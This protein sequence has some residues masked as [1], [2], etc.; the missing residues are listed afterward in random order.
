MDRACL[1][2]HP[3]WHRARVTRGKI[4]LAM[5]M[6]SLTAVAL[7]SPGV[8]TRVLSTDNTDPSY[9][10]NFDRYVHYTLVFFIVEFVFFVVNSIVFTTTYIKCR[11][12]I[13]QGAELRATPDCSTMNKG[14]YTGMDQTNTLAEKCFRIFALMYATF[15]VP[16]V[17]HSTMACYVYIR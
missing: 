15:F 3:L 10:R 5:L 17:I 6:A 4:S 8:V 12:S 14:S 11:R 9:Q 7:A 2:W 1:T 16:F 13:V